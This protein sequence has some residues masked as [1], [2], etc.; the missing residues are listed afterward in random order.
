MKFTIEKNPFLAA[1]RKVS[2]AVAKRSTIPILECFLLEI[3]SQGAGSPDGHV[4]TVSGSD[5][6][7]EIQT[8]LPVT[9]TRGGRI[10][11]RAGM[12]LSAIDALPG[13]AKAD[14]ELLED[15]R[16]RVVCARTRFHIPTLPANDFPAFKASTG[17]TIAVQAQELRRA[18]DRVIWA[19]PTTDAKAPQ[20]CG[21]FLHA[22]RDGLRLVGT[23]S[24]V[25]SRADLPTLS[26]IDR[27]CDTFP[28]T[29]PGALIP[30]GPLAALRK[31]LDGLDDTTE[32]KVTA[33]ER[34]AT[35]GMWPDTF[36]TQLLD[37]IYPGYERVID[38]SVAAAPHTATFPRGLMMEACR[39]VRALA[40]DKARGIV[41]E[42][43][44]TGIKA[45]TI[46]QDGTEAS[47]IL[48]VKTGWTRDVMR[49][50]FSSANI[51]P[52]LEVLA[53]AV[54]RANFGTITDATLWRA[55]QEA[56]AA[57]AEHLVLIMPY[58]IA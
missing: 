6:M 35:F 24:N 52:G 26:P 7:I 58:R 54:V 50:G 33:D 4:M 13:G 47:D 48:E 31:L 57:T 44:A 18:I 43:S 46:D 14:M 22:R 39:R 2:A 15:G 8:Q 49:I 40:M 36:S 1:L 34:R 28:S 5:T 29:S 16:L 21:A 20:L 45:S 55:E 51:L 10:A 30:T 42:I 32:V 56:D 12:L 38:F 23:N 25:F 17:E 11:V 3:G 19:I 27:F 37:L 41:F 9:T 53:G